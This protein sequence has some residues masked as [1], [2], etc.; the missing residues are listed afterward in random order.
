MAHDSA[1]AGNATKSF[2]EV[3]L[4]G[5]LPHLPGIEVFG[6]LNAAVTTLSCIYLLSILSAQYRSQHDAQFLPLLQL[7]NPQPSSRSRAS[8]GRYVLP[9]YH[10]FIAIAVLSGLVQGFAFVSPTTD[11]IHRTL[12]S[13]TSVI[14]LTAD[15]L[16]VVQLLRPVRRSEER[17]VGA[18]IL[19]AVGG[20]VMQLALPGG[21]LPPTCDFCGVHILKPNTAY[22]WC[23]IGTFFAYCALAT[24]FGRHPL[25]PPA[26]L[27]D[28]HDAATWRVRPALA[29]WCTFLAVP[30]L[31]SSVAI[32]FFLDSRPRLASG[33][34]ECT[35][36]GNFG[37]CILAICDAFYSIGYAPMLLRTVVADSSFARE[38]ML[39][40][41]VGDSPALKEW[42]QQQQPAGDPA[43]AQVAPAVGVQPLQAEPGALL[44]VLSIPAFQLIDV[45]DLDVRRRIGGGGFGDVSFALWRGVPVAVKQLRVEA[46]RG[47]VLRRLAGEART[48]AAL[49]HPNTVLFI[50]AT[51]SASGCALVTEYM[52]GGSVAD[53]IDHR[54]AEGGGVGGCG[55]RGGAGG[56]GGFAWAERMFVLQSAAHGMAY[57]HGKGILHRD[58]KS[59]NILV[60]SLQRPRAVKLCDFGLSLSADLSAA[61]VSAFVGTPQWCAPE[62]LRSDVYQ[63]A[64]D[65]YSFGVVCWEMAA[66]DTRPFGGMAPIRVAHEVAYNRLTL[67]L[68]PAAVAD[69]PNGF[70][71][72]MWR[73]L[74]AKPAERPPFNM[75]VEMLGALTP[76]ALPPERR[77]R[78]EFNIQ[79]IPPSS[80]QHEVAASGGAASDGTPSAWGGE[81]SG[82]P[83]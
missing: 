25:Q 51:L 17:T 40:D 49:R 2:C 32:F 22:V 77:G 55:G 62:V 23:A 64:S 70:V 3:V 33:E 73:C 78:V 4:K 83:C 24:E 8:P 65:V 56:G 50:G 31:T 61:S 68:P 46:A 36:S 66:L 7:L 74:R 60:D 37:F 30:F 80:E 39:I 11:A 54:R 19:L 52:P 35:S 59:A 27:C 69:A 18:S 45:S 47:D 16:V 20:L 13:L 57:L 82:S 10:T 6:L 43:A 21:L 9:R 5:S 1:A 28:E 71:A 76:D 48:L 14:S 81:R 34:Y 53:L 38:H 67:E 79:S 41:A 26:S 75:L 12:V 44:S 15:L 58:M 42:Q 72:L 29:G 63:S